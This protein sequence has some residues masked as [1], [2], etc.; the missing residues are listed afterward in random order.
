[1][2]RQ[3]PNLL[4]FIEVCR[5]FSDAEAFLYGY[6]LLDTPMLNGSNEGLRILTI[7][8]SKGLEFRHVIVM[9][10]LGRGS[11]G[12]ET[13]IF[14][15]EG[16]RLE[17]IAYRFAN[18]EKVDAEYAAL[19]ET[20][21]RMAKRDQVNTLYVAFTRARDSLVVL[22]KEKG[23]VFEP[24]NLQAQTVGR[25]ETLRPEQ[26]ELTRALQPVVY[27]AKNYG[28]Q[29]VRLRNERHGEDFDFY[30]VDTGLAF[31][32][33]MEMLEGFDPAAVPDAM[34]AVR[35]RFVLDAGAEEAVEGMVRTLL[36][37]PQFRELV[38]GS[39]CK[40]RSFIVD[41]ELGV[42]DLYVIDGEAIRVIDYKT[43]QKYAGYE[44]QIG[45]YVKALT[46]LYPEKKVSGYLCFVSLQH[47]VIEAVS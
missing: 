11:S 41:G 21:S 26:P 30:A 31:H 2:F 36:D 38:Q 14:H 24:L 3:D 39:A 44:E 10:R 47:A 42:I 43:G 45:R 23:S 34:T 33:A 6:E 7:H 9:D 15:Y 8:K 37:F 32:Y 17:K 28:R 20:E 25:V 5:Q 12:G 16:I 29:T 1:L 27:E 40:E 4:K 35:N 46:R 13:L 19:K 18:R 22:A